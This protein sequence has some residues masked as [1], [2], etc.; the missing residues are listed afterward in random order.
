MSTGG[1]YL[2]YVK[3]PALF[4]IRASGICSLLFVAKTQRRF[5]YEIENF[6][7]INRMVFSFKRWCIGNY[8]WYLSA[9]I[10]AIDYCTE[11]PAFLGKN[12]LLREPN[13]ALIYCYKH[14]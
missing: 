1:Y 13:C 12:T 14:Q 9:T 4:Q 10:I 3:T 11:K 6:A 2:L 5:L 8:N 7:K